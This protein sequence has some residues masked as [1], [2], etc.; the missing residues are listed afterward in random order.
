MLRVAVIDPDTEAR[1]N[2][3]LLLSNL[4]IGVE[5]FDAPPSYFKHTLFN[6]P[7]IAVV[8]LRQPG[9]DGLDILRFVIERSKALWIFAVIDEPVTAQIV[10]A[11]KMGA[12]DVL[13]RPIRIEPVVSAAQGRGVPAN[14]DAKGPNEAARLL[15][16]REREVL[17][18]L[19]AGD[20]NKAIAEKCGVSVRT[21]ETHRARIYSKLE[22]NSHAELLR[23]LST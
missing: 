6:E 1:K 23:K 16:K 5:A 7:H 22:V 8:A 14:R 11:V 20:T 2:L 12:T 19:L 18:R 15:T 17:K 10:A 21:I 13:E 3:T 4:E 9:F